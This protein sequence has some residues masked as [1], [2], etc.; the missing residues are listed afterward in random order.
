MIRLNGTH[1]LLVYDADGVNVLDGSAHTIK[2]KRTEALVV[3]S[4]GTGLKC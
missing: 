3:A 4:K 2:K 1:Q